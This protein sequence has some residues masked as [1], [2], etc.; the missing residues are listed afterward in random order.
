MSA[1]IEV[2]CMLNSLASLN[3]VN[4]RIVVISRPEVLCQ[5]YL[6]AANNWCCHEIPPEQVERDIWVFTEH[7]IDGHR[8]LKQQSDETKQNICRKLSQRANGMLEPLQDKI[9]YIE[10]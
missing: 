6:N 7:E 9:C 2:L 4:V 3:V 1:R 10:Y 8:A 5:Q